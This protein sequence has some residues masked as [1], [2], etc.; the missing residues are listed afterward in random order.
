M[1]RESDGTR[2]K[3]SLGEWIAFFACLLLLSFG[4]T[5]LHKIA[6]MALVAIRLSIILILSVLAVREWWNHHTALPHTRR[7][8]DFHET[9]LQRCRRWYYGE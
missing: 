1:N 4:A 8:G 3:H 5:P 6:D 9:I 2:K 7:A